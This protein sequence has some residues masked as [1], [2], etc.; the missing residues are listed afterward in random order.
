MT[1]RVFVDSITASMYEE[2]KKVY[3]E[4]KP[5]DEELLEILDRAEGVKYKFQKNK[6]NLMKIIE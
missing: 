6:M 4:N 2:I 5:A 1:I 3:N